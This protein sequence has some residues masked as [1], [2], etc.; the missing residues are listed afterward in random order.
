[1]DIDTTSINELPILSNNPS[2]SNT[3]QMEQMQQTTQNIVIDKDSVPDVKEQKHVR[4][5]DEPTIPRDSKQKND[6]QSKPT[7][8]SYELGIQTKICI[9][10][11]L[12]FFLLMDPKIKKYVL[13]ILVQVFGSFLKTEHGNMT[14]IGILVYALFFFAVLMVITKSIDISSFHLAV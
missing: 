8:M 10:A 1:M 4:F 6:V 12:I 2:N 14:Q 9:L 11:T 5:S 13:N 3:E 7:E